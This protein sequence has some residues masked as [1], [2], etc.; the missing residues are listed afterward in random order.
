MKQEQ[1]AQPHHND[2]RPPTPPRDISL[3]QQQQ[4]QQQERRRESQDSIVYHS[5]PLSDS[6]SSSSIGGHSPKLSSAEEA[7]A[8]AATIKGYET[9]TMEDDKILMAHVLTRLSGCRWKEA[10]LK[11]RG[12][13]N[14]VICEQRW[15]VLRD[16][17]IRG[18]NKSGTRGW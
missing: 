13:H 2:W 15:Q 8:A 6:S 14:A 5:P 3:L 4:N 9:W 1:L 7:N 17:L 18:A 12:R 16:L 10:E 11:L